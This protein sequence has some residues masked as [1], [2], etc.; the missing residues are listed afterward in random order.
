MQY[1]MKDGS[2]ILATKGGKAQC[3]QCGG[4]VLAKCGS[5]M[6][7]H[8]AHLSADCDPWAEPMTDWHLGWQSLVPPENREVVMSPHRA[9][10]RLND[11]LVVEI[12]HSPISAE[13]I[14][15]REKFYKNMIWIFD[16]RDFAERF[17]QRNESTVSILPLMEKDFGLPWG[18]RNHNHPDSLPHASFCIE[19]DQGLVWF[20]KCCRTKINRFTAVNAVHLYIDWSRARPTIASCKKPV[21]FDFGL[22]NLLY[23]DFSKQPK[24][25]KYEKGR[26]VGRAIPRQWITEMFHDA[27][28]DINHIWQRSELKKIPIGSTIYGELG[29]GCEFVGLNEDGTVSVLTQN[30]RAGKIPGYKV[31]KWKEPPR[32]QKSDPWMM[33]ND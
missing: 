33:T 12:Q 25:P 21:F 6:A 4:N 11:G 27:N 17:V 5:I 9:D 26:F 1:A 13:E 8:W 29:I 19:S 30:G 14:R 18:K 15:E 32:S 10:I 23:I 28:N 20:G 7:H 3:P 22:L 31:I 2:R 24:Q 16:A